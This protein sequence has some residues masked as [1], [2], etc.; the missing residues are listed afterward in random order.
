[1]GRMFV[2]TFATVAVL[3]VSV[4]TASAETLA[5]TLAD[6]YRN[7]ALLEQNRALLR[8]ADED[9]AQSVAALRP[10]INFVAQSGWAKTRQGE[11]L[12]S[13][14]ELS[15]QITLY[16]FGRNRLAVDS[17]REQVLATRQALIGL[18]QQVLLNAVQAYANVVSASEFV[19]LREAN[20]RLI[21]Q[22]LRAANDRFEVG[23]VTRTDVSI[24]EARL[25][26]ARANLAVAQGDY[27]IAVEQFRAAVGRDP[28]TLG[29]PGRAPA[30]PRSAE[31]A[32]SVA[33]RTHPTIRQAQHQVTA[34]ELDAERAQRATRGT[35]A[36]SANIGLDDGGRD[37]A[38]VGLRFSQPV[39]QGGALSSVYRKALAGRD[40]RRA[41]L[42]DAN[43]GVEREVGAAW[44]QLAVA[45]ASLRA[46]EEQIRAA[47][48][49]F[50]GVQEEARL[51]ART[52]LDV[53]NAEQELLDARTARVNAAAQQL[54]A[55]Y[56][57]LASMGLLTVEHLGL[58]VPVYDPSAYYDAVKNAPALSVQGERLDRVLRSIGQP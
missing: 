25:A 6:A 35:I 4:V 38:S 36:G 49:A 22:E 34:A 24:A 7:S 56:S 46:S 1:M 33:V 51:G 45:Q 9:V 43:R 47:T 39:Y 27:Q 11:G 2:R 40:A 50:E 53:L 17:A 54:V 52:T 55:V 42:L 48:V 10:V 28:G 26:G 20:T 14:V 57:L 32:K 58:G 13:S 44:S 41:A 3:A 8:A 30:T 5:D 37:S 19:R 21:T 31:E 18:E 12:S 23:E 16:D 29:N 15:A